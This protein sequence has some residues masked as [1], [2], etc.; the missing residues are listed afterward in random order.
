MGSVGHAIKWKEAGGGD[1]GTPSFGSLNY[2][3]RSS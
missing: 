2:Y 1:T 3:A